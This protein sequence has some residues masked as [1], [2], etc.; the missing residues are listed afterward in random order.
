MMNH[1]EWQALR[2]K[3]AREIWIR[4][5][6]ENDVT[7]HEAESQWDAMPAHGKFNRRVELGITA[8][9]AMMA[10]ELVR[11]RHG[12]ID[13]AITEVT[14]P[15]MTGVDFGKIMSLEFPDTNV[16]FATGEDIE[17]SHQIV[18]KPFEPED[19][20][21]AIAEKLLQRIQERRV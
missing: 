12:R 19:L 3:V 9:F 7:R 2:D 1:S 4:E 5:S 11:L 14:M 20:L 17:V 21:A 10:L 8:G 16:V 13:M 6:A 15:G 18:R